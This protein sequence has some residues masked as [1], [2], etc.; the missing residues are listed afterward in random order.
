MPERIVGKS[1]LYRNINL[2]TVN[3][4]HLEK[5]RLSFS[6]CRL[7][8]VFSSTCKCVPYTRVVKSLLAVNCSLTVTDDDDICFLCF[9]LKK[10][11]K[12]HCNWR[13]LM[14]SLSN[15]TTIDSVLDFSLCQ[16]NGEMCFSFS[17]SFLLFIMMFLHCLVD[18]LMFLLLILAVLRQ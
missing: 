3:E 10:K 1:H 13:M 7:V 15:L 18:K 12:L 17:F 5:Q 9:D 8:L 4:S 16:S 11:K 14:L 6:F 2:T